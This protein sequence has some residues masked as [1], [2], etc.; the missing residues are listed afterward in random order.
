MTSVG[1]PLSRTDG[2]L[3]VTGRARYT[4]DVSFSDASSAVIVHSTIASGRTVSID[5]S[6]AEKLRAWWR[7]SPR[8]TC[9]A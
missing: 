7:S 4:A 2:R 9:L 3:K 1:Q 5:T 8:A 6:A